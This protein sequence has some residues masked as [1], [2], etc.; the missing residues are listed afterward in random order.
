MTAG[1]WIVAHTVTHDSGRHTDHWEIVP[2]EKAA[3]D[4]LDALMATG[5]VYCACIAPVADGT[6][7]H[8]MDPGLH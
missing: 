4:K 2:G 6:E 3:R 5:G 8:W 7:P 1:S